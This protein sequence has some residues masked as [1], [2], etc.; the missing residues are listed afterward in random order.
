MDFIAAHAGGA[1][2]HLKDFHEPLRESAETRRRL[3]D[4]YETCRDQRKYVVISSP[5]RF[6]PEEIE[7]SVMFLELLPPDIPELVDLLLEEAPQLKPHSLDGV[8]EA[9]LEQLARALLGLTLDEAGY[10][11][12]RALVATPRLGPES[13][14]YLLEEKRVL[15]SRSGVVDYVSDGTNLG[16]VGGLEGMK[17]WLLERQ[18]LFQM[19][20]QLTS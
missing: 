6:I 4:I 17:K 7:R 5:V 9:E 19:R 13:V 14:P 11:L 20:D 15:V 16:E 2:F 18:K 8:G 12:R 10:A 1:I 3:R